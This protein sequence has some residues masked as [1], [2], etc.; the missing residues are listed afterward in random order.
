MAPIIPIAQS[1]SPSCDGTGKTIL[2]V[3]NS[4]P[5]RR[6]IIVQTGKSS[7][8]WRVQQLTILGEQRRMHAYC[9]CTCLRSANLFQQSAEAGRE[10]QAV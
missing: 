4:G 10:F 8:S 2:N 9:L 3:A 1:D 5:Y 7:D 6:L